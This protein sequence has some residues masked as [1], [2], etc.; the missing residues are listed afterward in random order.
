MLYNEYMIQNQL[1]EY[2]SS[3]IKAGV[4]R[5]AVKSALIGVGWAEADVEDTL[6]KVEGASGPAAAA[7]PASVSPRPVSSVSFPASSASSAGGASGMGG[8]ATAP[9]TIRMSDL[10]SASSAA[11]SLSMGGAAKGGTATSATKSQPANP[12]KF[13]KTGGGA[14]S[15]RGMKI[16]G[17]V[18]IVVFAG[19]AGYLYFENSGLSAQ[20]ASLNG[21]SSGIS[22]QITTLNAQVQALDASDTALTAQVASLMQE[23]AD[24]TTNLSFVA[25]PPLSS[26]TPAA[27]TISISGMLT[28]GKSVYALTTPYGVVAYVKNA[29]DAKVIAALKP[30]ANGTS[31]VILT[32]DHVPGSQYLTVTTVNGSPL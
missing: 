6:K 26:G 27:E 29:A 28:A 10:V 11:P 21:Q 14:G 22:A 15:G 32:G 7:T 9:K 2:I 19:L 30:L 25:A 20:V 18:L 17:I 1:V 8:A 23:N 3:Q 13:V 31:T 4:P 24:L 16:V 5:A 12:T